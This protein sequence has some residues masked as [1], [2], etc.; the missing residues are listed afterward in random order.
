MPGCGQAEAQRRNRARH[1]FPLLA[2]SGRAEMQQ[3][4]TSEAHPGLID[5]LNYLYR[6]L[7]ETWQSLCKLSRAEIARRSSQFVG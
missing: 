7:A 3:I 5:V 4:R 6:N 2:V 1:L